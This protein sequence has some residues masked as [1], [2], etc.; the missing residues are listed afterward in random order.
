MRD[1]LSP[2]GR[3]A[4]EE[5]ARSNVLLGFDFDGT[6]APIV[7]DPASARLRPSTRTLLGELTGRYP[8]AIVSGRARDDVLRLVEG[9][10]LMRI[11][12]NHGTEGERPPRN[13]PREAIGRWHAHLSRACAGLSG[14][15]IEDKT[16]SLAIHYRRAP[17][18]TVA[19]GRILAAAA[20][21]PDARIVHGKAVVN[22]V[23]PAAA[24][25]GN[26]IL[27]IRRQLCCE[28]TLYVGDDVTD[29]DVFSLDEPGRLL[30]VRVGRARSTHAKFYLRSQDLMDELL[31]TLLSLRPAGR[32]AATR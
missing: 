29:E 6:L 17:R 27:D 14:V 24:H 18:R 21:L 19:R 28:T 22:L 5:F 25:K 10:P 3:A 26:A 7:D 23:H 15:L 2:T 20:E 31:A 32:K 9:L 30:A 1:I 12:G 13:V 8:C 11:V 4:L 16:W